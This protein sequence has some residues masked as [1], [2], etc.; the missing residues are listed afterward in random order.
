MPDW[1]P[2]WI[3]ELVILDRSVV[4]L[5]FSFSFLGF[6]GILDFGIAW[7]AGCD[8]CSS[9]ECDS[10]MMPRACDNI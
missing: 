10:H 8:P 2:G 6:L 3:L 7:P 5:A 4:F 9:F 1:A